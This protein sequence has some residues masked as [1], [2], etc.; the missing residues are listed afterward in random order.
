MITLTEMAIA[1]VK[2][3]IS[4][5]PEPVAGLR[6]TVQVDDCAGLKYHVG[7]EG[8][9]REGDAV[10]E[11]GGVKVFVDAG[12][13]PHIAGSTLDFVTDPGSFGFI[14]DNPNAPEECACG[15]SCG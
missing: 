4:Q 2:G 6:I 12:S 8:E 3:V 11:T 5:A 9:S 15:K 1:A 7:L 10:I 13:Q 14:F